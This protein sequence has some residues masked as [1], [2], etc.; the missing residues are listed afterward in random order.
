MP[1]N[2]EDRQI[3]WAQFCKEPIPERTFTFWDWF[4]AVMKLTRDQLRGPWTEGLI[5]GFISKRQAEEKLLKCPPGTFLLRFSDSE[6]GMCCG[7]VWK[8][9][10]ENNN[11]LFHFCTQQV[12]LR[13]LGLNIRWKIH[14]RLWCCNR[15]YTKILPYERW[16]IVSRICPNASHCIRTYQRNGHLEPIIH[17]SEVSIWSFFF[18]IYIFYNF[19]YFLSVAAVSNG[20]VKPELKLVVDNALNS[21]PNTPQHSS[22]TSQ[23]PDRTRETSSVSTWVAIYNLSMLKYLYLTPYRLKW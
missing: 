22:W 23:S 15:F 4:Y 3:N 18:F 19:F 12:E 10:L 7:F 21:Y 11:P 16:V 5:I 8:Q 17:R 1:Y 20:Y 2:S 13:L 14:Y 9:I 6:L